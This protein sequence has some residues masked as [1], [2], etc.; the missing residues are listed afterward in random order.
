MN[1]YWTGRTRGRMQRTATLL[2]L[3]ALAGAGCLRVGPGED[4]HL[5]CEEKTGAPRKAYGLDFLVAQTRVEGNIS[6]ERRLSILEAARQHVVTPSGRAHAGFNAT[7]SRVSQDEWRF[8]AIG[9]WDDAPPDE[10]RVPIEVID[11]TPRAPTLVEAPRSVRDVAWRAANQ[12][13]PGGGSF[14]E[15]T[16]AVW[17]PGLPSCVRLGGDEREVV[18]NVAQG[19]VVYIAR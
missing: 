11:R 1:P 6:D 3:L 13:E 12:S 4:L 19:R 9:V 14:P 18:V 16:L 15:P 2:V 7:L 8:D 17:D 10:Y 5:V